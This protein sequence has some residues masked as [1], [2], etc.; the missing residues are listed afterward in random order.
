VE[1]PD[2]PDLLLRALLSLAGYDLWSTRKIHRATLWAS[3]F[4]AALMQ[5][6]TPIGRTAPW[7][8]FATWVLS[9][10]RSFR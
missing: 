7:Q 10:V 5:V 4:V 9:L 2:S 6:R 3:L 1:S 8:G